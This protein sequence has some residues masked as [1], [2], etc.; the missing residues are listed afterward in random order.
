M[1]VLSL[2]EG[3]WLVV[4]GPTVTLSR[5]CLRQRSYE[6]NFGNSA[7]VGVNMIKYKGGRH[8]ASFQAAFVC[9]MRSGWVTFLTFDLLSKHQT[10]HTGFRAGFI[11]GAAEQIRQTGVTDLRCGTART[12]EK[13]GAGARCEGA[14]C[15]IQAGNSHLSSSFRRE[16]KE[17][18]L[19]E[20]NPSPSFSIRHCQVTVRRFVVTLWAEQ[21]VDPEFSVVRRP[22]H[23]SQS[24]CS[25]KGETLF[26]G[27]HSWKTLIMLQSLLIYCLY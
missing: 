5:A 10:P 8:L 16:Q 26:S 14:P 2:L 20:K 27:C 9:L 22:S 3:V 24:A 1:A 6:S 18:E 19:E 11:T 13:S 17:N 23:G 15:F 7:T 21:K 4:A 25:L 12:L